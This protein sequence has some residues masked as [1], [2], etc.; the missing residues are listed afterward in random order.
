MRFALLAL[1][2]LF[3]AGVVYALFSRPEASPD[4]ATSFSLMPKL[5]GATP[6]PEP[7]AAPEAEQ[8][9]EAVRTREEFL[10]RFG[11]E[12]KFQV[13]GAEFSTFLSGG[14][15]PGA[16]PDPRKALALARALAPLFGVDP[17]DIGKVEE[18]P[19][20]T[21]LKNYRI[22]QKYRGFEVLERGLL[23]QARAENGDVFAIQSDLEAMTGD[24]PSVTHT[25]ADALQEAKS[26]TGV[27]SALSRSDDQPEVWKTPEGDLRL[28][29][30][31]QSAPSPTQLEPYEAYVDASS[32]KVVKKISLVTKD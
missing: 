20:G 4:A 1:L 8:G 14:L 15:I 29:Y 21:L 22:K 30:R 17:G 12:W 32:G 3:L 23:I 6:S 31:V 19:T 10:S 5:S 26:V 9:L 13:H 27:H 18:A 7:T 25:A 24:L 28:V 11:A 2:T 16:G